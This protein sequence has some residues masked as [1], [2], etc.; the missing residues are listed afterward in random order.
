M[1]TPKR[2]SPVRASTAYH[3]DQPAFEMKRLCR[4]APSVAG[5]LGLGLE[6]GQIR[7]AARLGQAEARQ[8]PAGSDIRDDAALQRVAAERD[9][10]R[11]R[12]PRDQQDKCRAR[13]NPRHLLDRDDLR[14]QVAATAAERFGE[15]EA[16]QLERA[17]RL[18]RFARKAG[19]VIDRGGVRLDPRLGE[20]PDVVAELA[21]ALG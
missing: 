20:A 21:I 8:R 13:A 10:R 7:P 11:Q 12:G 4:E 15:G 6:P 17:K 3:S 19:L 9:E 5:A 18:D 14:Q 1:K 16:G 2:R